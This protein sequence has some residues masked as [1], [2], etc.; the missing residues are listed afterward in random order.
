MVFV[1]V[2]FRAAVAVDSEVIAVAV[3]VADKFSADAEVLP[4]H[5][6]GAPGVETDGGGFALLTPRR[7]R[8]TKSKRLFGSRSLVALYFVRSSLSSY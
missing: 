7:R 6:V 4:L 8:H 3:V 2:E 5:V 1:S